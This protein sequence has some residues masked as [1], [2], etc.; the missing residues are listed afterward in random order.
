MDLSAGKLLAKPVQVDLNTA[1]NGPAMTANR[2]FL[3]P[4]A[5]GIRVI[6]AEQVLPETVVSF[7]TAVNLSIAEAKIF[8]EL[9]TQFVT[10]QT[11]Q[12]NGKNAE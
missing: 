12:G 11:D 7:R 1:V 5:N 2:F 3:I 10:S 8:L 6:F 4:I 9:F